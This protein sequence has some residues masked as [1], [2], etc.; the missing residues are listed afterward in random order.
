MKK[1]LENNIKE[2]LTD[3]EMPYDNAAWEKLNRQLDLLKQAN[4][5]STVKWLIVSTLIAV[6]ATLSMYWKTQKDIQQSASSTK[7]T[8]TKNIAASTLNTSKNEHPPLLDSSTIETNIQPISNAKRIHCGITVD[9]HRSVESSKTSSSFPPSLTPISTLPILMHLDEK[10]ANSLTTNTSVQVANLVCVGEKVAISNPS[11]LKLTINNPAGT[12]FFTKGTFTAEHEGTY[13]VEYLEQ[14]QLVTKKVQSV[15]V[16]KVDFSIEDQNTYDKGLPIVNLATK[17]TGT[18]TWELE[19]QGKLPSTEEISVRYFKKGSYALTLSVQHST[20][21]KSTVNKS[22]YIEEDYNLLA[23]TG[24]DPS[25][26]DA[27]KN[28]FM[29]YA[30]TQRAVHFDMIIIDSQNG[31]VV[32][33][34]TDANNPW[35]GINRRTGQ[36]VEPKKV[37]V[38]KVTLHT[39]ERGESSEY[40]GVITRV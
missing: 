32:F 26:N 5:K 10:S 18:I 7:K 13:S 3:F 2:S 38:W 6:V 14:G 24:F 22:V 33:E 40:K 25:S 31:E 34:T 16:P 12:T 23:V 21:C 27:R 17:A 35:N 11:N 37:F 8:E 4:T 39:T 1:D 29:P 30:L 36:L 20:G 15:A 28:V 9:N 19:K